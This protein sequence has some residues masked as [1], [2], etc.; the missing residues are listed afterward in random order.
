M[1]AKR[2]AA[3]AKPASK[4]SKGE[5]VLVLRTC[6]ADLTSHG[7]FQWPSE[8]GAT[9]SAPDWKK[10]DDCGNGLHGWLYGQ[11][12]HG[13][14]NSIGNVDAKWIVVEVPLASVVMLGGKCKF[15][16]CVVRHI[17]DKESATAYLIANEP[18]AK[19]VAVIG[20]TIIAGAGQ[21][22]A[23]GGLGTAT[24]GDRGTATAGYSGTATAGYSGT[25]TAG[26]R[27]T[28]T[29]GDSGTATAGYS[30]TAT[31]G[32]SGTA[33]AGD[34]G[35]A[36]AGYSGTATAGYRG[37][38]TAGYSGTATAGYSGTATAGYSGTATAGDSGT[39][40]AGDS[41]T[42]TA[43]DRGTA[44][45]GDRGT[46]TAGYSGTATAGDSGTICL[47]WY[48]V[49]ADRYRIEIAYVGEN[50]IKPNTRYRLDDNRRF[51]EVKP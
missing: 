9:V 6:N 23:V 7:G 2:K 35:T 12:D 20:A 31:A 24:A 17:G 49:R 27:G 10:T 43:G 30:G 16:S 3:S 37:T 39:A 21:T 42:A 46:A 14:S 48:D 11:G 47:K 22:A 4:K 51:V 44:T 34:S 38:A 18:R 33:T 19:D 13:A 28:A 36:T 5:T 1:K 45:A 50:G 40:T 29:A 8:I 15:P 32:Y 26:D 25:A 41:G